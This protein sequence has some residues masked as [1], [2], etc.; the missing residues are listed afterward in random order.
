MFLV[1]HKIYGIG[2]IHRVPFILL[3]ERWVWPCACVAGFGW[4]WRT[5]MSWI[6]TPGLCKGRSFWKGMP[7]HHILTCL[8]CLNYK[9]RCVLI[10]N[11]QTTEGILIFNSTESPFLSGGG[12]IHLKP[13]NGMQTHNVYRLRPDN[14]FFYINSEKERGN[15]RQDADKSTGN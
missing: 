6:L 3:F 14:S 13:H 5:R 9:S 1:E 11:F 15:D 4:G 7:C 2:S 8:S 10:F 12:R